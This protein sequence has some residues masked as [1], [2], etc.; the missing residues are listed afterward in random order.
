MTH[1]RVAPNNG[2]PRY[3]V[4][5]GHKVENFASNIDAPKFGVEI[6]QRRG[7][8]GIKRQAF[9][10]EPLMEGE[11][12]R[13]EVERR[14]SFEKTGEGVGVRR[15]MGFEHRGVGNKNLP[16]STLG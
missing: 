5:H 15:D 12:E 4:P 8:V 11:T 14:A 13:K 16:V 10:K 1:A 9:N 7:N 6:D 3:N 2:G